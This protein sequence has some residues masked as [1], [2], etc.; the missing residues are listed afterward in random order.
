MSRLAVSTAVLA[1]A[2]GTAA[3]Q[4]PTPVAEVVV[5]AGR[6][7]Q[8]LAA[9]PGA[10]VIGE[11]DIERL[12]ATV[13]TD[14]LRLVPGLS[15][16]RNGAFGG[17]S[18]VRQRGAASDKTLVL[19]DGVPVNDPASPSGGLD[20]SILDLADVSRIEVLSGPQGSLWGSDAIGGVI[21]FTTRELDG[22]RA[23]AE[24][25][26]FGVFRGSAAAGLSTDDYAYGVSASAFD[27]DGISKADAADGNPEADGFRNLTL[28]A[29]GRLRLSDR[30]AL[31]GRL[32][33]NAAETQIDGFPAPTFRLAD[34]DERSESDSLTGFV[35]ARVSDVAGF[36]HAISL[37][38]LRSDRATLGGDFPSSLSA[39]RAVWRWQAD[40]ARPRDRW[41]LTIGAEREDTEADL[42]DGARQDLG[43]TAVFAVAR[44][45]ASGRLTLTGSVR[46]DD[47]DRYDGQ[48]TARLAAAYDLGSGVTVSASFGQGFKT[49]TISQTACDFCFPAGPA[50]NLRPETAE[51]FDARLAWRSS[52]DGRFDAAATAWRLEVEDQIDFVF[53]PAD[54]TFRYRNI[55]RT[56]ATGLELEGSARLAGGF[57]ARAAYGY[58]DAEDRT[59]GERL[60]RIPEHQGSATLFWSG[61]RADAALTVRAES[62]QADAGGERD[63]FAVV[64]VAGSWGVTDRV[65]LT[66]RVENL[67]DARYQEALGY[68]EP[69]LSAYVG[70]RLR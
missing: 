15:V 63:G 53:D 2:A 18:S 20:F 14:V 4:P 46:H 7:P 66:A 11:R 52:A 49:P 60:L 39:R 44:V 29:N 57:E 58:T 36:D 26:S 8:P 34:T 25:G 54:F 56:R 55:D 45:R 32:R 67:F 5:T 16:S 13:A 22:W 43:A 68:G 64:D 19:I 28:G 59:T 10:R 69:G 62:D 23:D 6:L 30:V 40:R 21:A 65:R 27:A 50:T 33:Y 42:S 51:G 9:S 24:A 48:A 17:I 38:G 41:A 70:V 47:P 3:A 31:D 12:Q 37:S 1:L 35:R 61:D